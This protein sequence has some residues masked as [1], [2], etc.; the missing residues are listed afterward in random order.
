MKK[1][2]IIDDEPNFCM[3]LKMNLELLGGFEVST[4]TSGEEGIGTAKKAKPDLILLD[5]LMPGMD[6][7]KVLENL[8]KDKATTTIPVAMLTAKEDQAS[9]DMALQLRADEFIIKPIET[10]DLKVK[11]EK[12]LTRK[13]RK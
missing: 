3:L 7:F 12:I 5:I 10:S 13:K 2:L 11:I 9:K 1:I 4:A 8:K 6:G